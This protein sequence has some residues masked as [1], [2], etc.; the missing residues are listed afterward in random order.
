MEL[1]FK[2]YELSWETLIKDIKIRAAEAIR[3][4]SESLKQS[5]SPEIILS[6]NTEAPIVANTTETSIATHLMTALSPSGI[7]ATEAPIVANTT[8]TS[9]ASQFMTALYPSG[10]NAPEATIVANT[11]NTSVATNF[12]TALYPSGIND[13]K[14]RSMDL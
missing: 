10:I 2:L 12:M 6:S 9:V 11:T 1:Y 8:D 14:V 4:A 5:K 7:I 13:F 3:L